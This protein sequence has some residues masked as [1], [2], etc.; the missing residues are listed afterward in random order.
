MNTLEKH[1]SYIYRHDGISY[2]LGTVAESKG[3]V[4]LR[5]GNDSFDN[6]DLKD[7]RVLSQ[8]CM[9]ESSKLSD[10]NS[11]MFGVEEMTITNTLTFLCD[12]GFAEEEFNEFKATSKGREI[13]SELAIEVMKFDK[14]KYKQ[15]LEEILQMEKLVI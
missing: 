1:A 10:F 15:G 11:V 3:V 4:S 6:L 9:S 8:L 14:F 13:I 2:L 7:I 12:L 5:A